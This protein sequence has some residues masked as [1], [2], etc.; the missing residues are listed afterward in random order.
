MDEYDIEQ[1]DTGYDRE[2]GAIYARRQAEANYQTGLLAFTLVSRVIGWQLRHYRAAGMRR[3]RLY[4][5]F[6][7]AS[8]ASAGLFF[9]AEGT[10]LRGGGLAALGVSWAVFWVLALFSIA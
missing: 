6:S 7:L 9:Y 8:L 10:G 3:K 4:R 2:I 1:V 5:A